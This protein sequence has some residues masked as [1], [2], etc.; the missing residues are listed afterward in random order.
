MALHG[1]SETFPPP[2]GGGRSETPDLAEKPL[3]LDENG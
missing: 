1:A 3:E 2:Q